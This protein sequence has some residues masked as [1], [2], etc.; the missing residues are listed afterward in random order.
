[1]LGP[2]RLCSA[3]YCFIQDQHV[4]AKSGPKLAFHSYVSVYF[5]QTNVT[6]VLTLN[7]F[8]LLQYCRV[9]SS[10]SASVFFL[11]RRCTPVFREEKYVSKDGA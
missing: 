1:M 5:K 3:S 11:W 7:I 8:S 6:V 9:S 2:A 4:A 10:S